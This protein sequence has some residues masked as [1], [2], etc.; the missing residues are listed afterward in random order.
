MPKYI[1]ERD[2][3]GAGRL[4]ADALRAISQRSCAVI[5]R[6]G[7]RLQWVQSYVTDDKLYCVYIASGEE[8]IREHARQGDFP[9]NRI[10]KVETII[11]P[12]TSEG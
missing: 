3:P 7:P 11:D 8:A 10:A 2:V 5:E 9:A 12:V 1:I 6:L 4:T